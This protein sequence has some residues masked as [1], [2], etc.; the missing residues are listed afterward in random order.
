MNTNSPGTASCRES[1]DRRMDKKTKTQ[2]K[3]Q[4]K[5]IIFDVD[6]TLTYANSWAHLT[7][8]LGIDPIENKKIYDNFYNRRVSREDAIKQV[9]DLWNRDKMRT[10]DEITKILHSI[11]I[12][13]DAKEVIDY[14]KQKG[15]G[16]TIASGSMDINVK[17]VAKELGIKDWHALAEFFFNSKDELINFTYPDNESEGKLEIFQRIAKKYKISAEE[18][19]IIGDGYSDIKLIEHLGLSIVIKKEDNEEICTMGDYVITD[20]MELKEI[21]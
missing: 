6:E 15:Y 20:L 10:R 3:S 16:I 9:V 5:H 11:Q 1:G 12:K 7:K 14:L 19:A 4:I 21:F 18:C 13:P 8:G 17:R 2:K